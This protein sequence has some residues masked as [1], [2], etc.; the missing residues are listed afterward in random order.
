MPSARIAVNVVATVA[1]A[2]C[3]AGEVFCAMMKF[4]MFVSSAALPVSR[5]RAKVDVSRCRTR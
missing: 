3:P 1:R 4:W 2:V 5:S